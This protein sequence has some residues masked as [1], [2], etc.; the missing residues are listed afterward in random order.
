[1]TEN[2]NKVI[3]KN[4]LLLSIRTVIVLFITLYTT[5][6]ILK[7]L[8]VEDFGVY[9]VVGGFVSMFAFLNSSMSNGI[10]RFF[11]YEY[12]TNG[13]DGATKVYNTSLRIQI[14]LA[15]LVLLLTESFGLWYMHNK[16]VIPPERFVAALFIYQ[17]SIISLVLVILQ[18]PFTAAVMAHERMDFFA[19]VSM[20]DA[21]ARLGIAFIISYINSDR[22]ILYGSL[23]LFVNTIDLLAY[24]FYTKRNFIEIQL[25]KKRTGLFKS[26]LSFSGWN[27]FG[28]FANIMKEQG[29]NLVLNIYLGPI[30]NAARGIAA[31]INSGLQ[32]LVVNLSIAVRPQLVQSYAEGNVERS[33]Q[34]VYTISKFSCCFLYIFSLPIL[35]EIDTILN[36]WLGS[37]IPNHT[38]TF[39]Y[40]IILTSFV[41]NLNAAI[42]N[43]VHASGKMRLYQVTGGIAILMAIPMA[44]LVLKWGYEPEWALGMGCFSMIIAQILALLVL[45]TIVNYSIFDYL[46]KVIYPLVLLVILSIP[47]IYLIHLVMN[48]GLIRLFVVLLSSFV[49]IGGI[50]YKITLESNE[51]FFINTYIMSIKKRLL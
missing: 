1:M 29:M 24:Y 20:I 45:K 42:S 43:I 3:A 51:R 10:Q 49:I 35:L 21:L 25:Q 31:Q 7:S 37:N 15:C 46:K 33:I 12:K 41:N 47:P 19:F 22:L 32:N 18:V 17:T 48:E 40:I 28:T 38:N 13:I 4:T 9:N 23:L 16:M 44:Y 50:I 30:V 2:K 5:R 6:I 39:V 8:G 14:L 26:M 36:I 27:I 11:N 34:L